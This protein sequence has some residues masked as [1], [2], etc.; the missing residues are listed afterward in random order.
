[1]FRKFLEGFISCLPFISMSE[2]ILKYYSIDLYKNEWNVVGNLLNK[3]LKNELFN[4]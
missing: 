3:K 2:N 4:K 1:M